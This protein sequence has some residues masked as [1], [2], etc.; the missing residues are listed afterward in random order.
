MVN[1]LFKSKCIKGTKGTDT[2]V[3]FWFE[4]YD[5]LNNDINLQGKKE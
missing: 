1:G 5:I 3:P 2:F 4:I